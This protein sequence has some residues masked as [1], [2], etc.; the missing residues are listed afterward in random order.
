MST[1]SSLFYES[2]AVA[3]KVDVSKLKKI[4]QK[5]VKK[6]QMVLAELAP[7]AI[8]A[9]IIGQVV[10]ITYKDISIKT[11]AHTSFLPAERVFTI[12]ADDLNKWTFYEY[13][14]KKGVWNYFKFPGSGGKRLRKSRKTRKS[15]KAKTTRKAKKSRKGNSRSRK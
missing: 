2:G 1:Q 11:T 7:R 9:Y 8:G 15:R 12:S 5:D 14:P 4:E 3:T 13:P 10:E 6:D